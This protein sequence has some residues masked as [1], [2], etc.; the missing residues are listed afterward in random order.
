MR[1]LVEATHRALNA[2]IS[3]EQIAAIALDTT[4]SSVIPVG[5]G[6]VLVPLDECCALD[7]SKK[8]VLCGVS[9]Q[10]SIHGSF[11]IA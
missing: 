7:G 9:Q 6:L 11:W 3:G 5:E 1:A 4:G 2:A 8:F 10:H